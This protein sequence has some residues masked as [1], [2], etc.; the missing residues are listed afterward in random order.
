MKYVIVL[1]DGM[2]DRP[3]KENG[4]KTALC[5]ANLPA[6]TQMAV[7][8]EVGM[9]QTVPFG[10]KPGSDVANL[11]VLGFDP[12]VYYTGRSPIEALSM[13][14]DFDLTDVTYRTNL[15]H[16]SNGV[17]G[18]DSRIMSHSAGDITTAEAAL[19][20]DAVAKEIN[21]EFC[22]LFTGVSYRH[23]LILRNS[24][25]GADLTPPHDV[26]GR[27]VSDNLP[28]GTHADL[29]I[30]IMARAEKILESHPVNVARKARGLMTANSLWFWGEGRKPS[31]PDFATKY[32]IK[33]AMVSAVDLLKGI[34]VGSGMTVA[35][36]EGATGNEHTNYAGKGQAAIDLLTDHDFVFVHVEAPDECGHVGNAQGKVQA[37]EN[38]DRQ[39]TQR[40]LDY[41]REQKAD[42]SVLF[43]PDHATPVEIMTHSGEAVPYVLW[44]SNDLKNNVGAQYNEEYASATGNKFESGEALIKHFL[45]K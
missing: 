10:M 16:L 38:I 30:D 24:D 43:L 3:S 31:L 23:C 25:T 18:K 44:K 8:G 41:A 37:I 15:V 45:Q 1:G 5:A 34:A 14:I 28:R 7:T 29:L 32:G 2:A 40:L 17:F 9:V 12:S 22:Q 33:G 19:L 13:G 21:S 11:S 6:A 20:I 26:I 4:F 42:L 36:V 27:P 35:E 39:I